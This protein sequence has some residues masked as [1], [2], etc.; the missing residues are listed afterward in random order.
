MPIV[1]RISIATIVASLALTTAAIL[2]PITS[3]CTLFIAGD[4][5]GACYN[6]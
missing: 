4:P 5:S 3:G 6:R 2:V 1:T